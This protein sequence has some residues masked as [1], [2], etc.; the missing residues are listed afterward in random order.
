MK[1]LTLLSV[2]DALETIERAG[3]N[4]TDTSIAADESV[5]RLLKG[6]RLEVWRWFQTKPDGATCDA[7][8]QALDLKHQTCSARV[9]E[10]AKAGWLVDTGRRAPT[11]SGRPA[12]VY[13]A[14][15]LSVV[16]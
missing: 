10:L 7:A 13:E 1:Q 8:E 9:R 4:G 12:R 2:D 16:G 11:S 5:S 15:D 14:V 6:L 3:N